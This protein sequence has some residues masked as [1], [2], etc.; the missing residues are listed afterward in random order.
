MEIEKATARVRELFEMATPR[1]VVKI[2]RSIA[3]K[4]QENPEGFRVILAI[5]LAHAKKIGISDKTIK[6]II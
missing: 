3:L 1:M 5:G 4:Y 6:K 2:L